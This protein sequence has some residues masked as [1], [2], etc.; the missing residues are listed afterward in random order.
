M[1]EMPYFEND[2]VVA[3]LNCAP[4]RSEHISSIFASQLRKWDC[5]HIRFHDLRHNAATNMHDLTDDF[6]TISEILGHTTE[7][8]RLCLGL[9]RQVSNMTE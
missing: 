3:Q 9:M 1:A 5:R 7:G 8:M 6:Y 2:L 4:I